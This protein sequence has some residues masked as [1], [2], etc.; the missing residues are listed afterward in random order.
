MRVN[1][2]PLVIAEVK[3]ESPFGFKSPHGWRTLLQDAVDVGDVVSIHVDPEWGGSLD[4]LHEARGKTDLPILAKG[5]HRT[6]DEIYESLGAG[7]QL[8]LVV[9]RIPWWKLLPFCLVEPLTIADAKS[10][11]K[12]TRIV[13]N[14]RNV[15]TGEPKA[16]T[17]EEARAAL[18][19][20]WMCQASFVKTIDDVSVHAS[21]VLVGQHLPE[22]AEDL[23]RRR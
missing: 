19:H 9:G 12:D 8:V 15:F 4:L 1:V 10:L 18:D 7:A 17:F 3:T 2:R 5:F 21:A 14:Q 23:K 11:P 20:L 6:D 22:F 16:E 13:W